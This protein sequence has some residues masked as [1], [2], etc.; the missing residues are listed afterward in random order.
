MSQVQWTDPGEED[1]CDP[2]LYLVT[3]VLLVLRWLV[4][5]VNLT[6]FL[7]HISIASIL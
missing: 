7:A 1:Y 2:L 6:V 3:F 4:L 5:L